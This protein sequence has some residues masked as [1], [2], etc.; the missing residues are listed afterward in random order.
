M[1][2][3]T[4][5]VA[6]DMAAITL[7]SAGGRSDLCNRKQGPKT[8]ITKVFTGPTSSGMGHHLSAQ[9]LKQNLWL[10]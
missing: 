5:P 6:R 2:T 10:S 9:T 7:V 1:A 8:E 4:P 3:W